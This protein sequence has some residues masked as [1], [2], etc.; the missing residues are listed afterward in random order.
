MN[1]YIDNDYQ[2]DIQKDKVIPSAIDLTK[3]LE[4][5]NKKINTKSK[6][7]KNVWTLSSNKWK[8]LNNKNK[9]IR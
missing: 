6:I 4:N 5:K 8:K 3:D 7:N 9:E 1:N 2:I